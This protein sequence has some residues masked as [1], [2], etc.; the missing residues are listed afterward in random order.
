[1]TNGRTY[2]AAQGEALLPDYSSRIDTLI[3]TSAALASLSVTWVVGQHM[4]DSEWRAA[5]SAQMASTADTAKV[6][7]LNMF[8]DSLNNPHSIYHLQSTDAQAN[9]QTLGATADQASSNAMFNNQY[10]HYQHNPDIEGIVVSMKDN[11]PTVHTSLLLVNDRDNLKA[12]AK[13][14]D[15]KSKSA[16][17]LNPVFEMFGGVVLSAAIAA[18]A[19]GLSRRTRKRRHAQQEGDKL[20]R[21]AEAYLRL[22]TPD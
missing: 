4:S 22:E 12:E 3:G 7:F 9:T 1:M 2:Y 17:T 18:G 21:E 14:A 15:A 20:A 5:E 10:I 19:Y 13:Q 11:K 16:L 8:Y 6:S